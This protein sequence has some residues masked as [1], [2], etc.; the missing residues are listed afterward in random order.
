MA[1]SVLQCGLKD[2]CICCDNWDRCRWLL[3]RC[4]LASCKSQSI[5]MTCVFTGWLG[6]ILNWCRRKIARRKQTDFPEWNARNC[7]FICNRK[8]V[9]S[10]LLSTS[11]KSS[12]L[13]YHMQNQFLNM[14]HNFVPIKI[15]ITYQAQDHAFVQLIVYLI[16]IYINSISFIFKVQKRNHDNHKC[17]GQDGK[18]NVIHSMVRQFDLIFH[19]ISKVFHFFRFKQLR[20]LIYCNSR[21]HWLIFWFFFLKVGCTRAQHAWNATK[22]TKQIPNGECRN[23]HSNRWMFCFYFF[24]ILIS[25]IGHFDWSVYL[26]HLS[27]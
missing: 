12:N 4:T 17:A 5:L 9:V 15:F 6:T 7:T 22:W 13:L 3:H 11:S 18:W 23:M 26:L 14:P 20:H 2:I 16:Y 8:W 19:S 25:S 27:K 1:I 24:A 10:L 21:F